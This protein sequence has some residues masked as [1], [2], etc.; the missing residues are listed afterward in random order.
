MATPSLNFW[1]WEET[2]V[3]DLS[4]LAPKKQVDLSNLKIKDTPKLPETP[5]TPQGAWLWPVAPAPW[6]RDFLASLQQTW[7]DFEAQATDIWEP[8]EAEPPTFNIETQ[9][10]PTWDE[11]DEVA[12]ELAP[13]EP[14]KLDKSIIKDF[15]QQWLAKWLN[16]EQLRVAFEKGKSQWRFDL[17]TEEVA[18]TPEWVTAQ[19]VTPPEDAWIL[20]KAKDIAEIPWR[21]AW[22]WLAQVPKILSNIGW[23]FIWKPID[24]LL[25]KVWVDESSLEEAFKKDWIRNKE[26]FQEKLWIDSES[27][28]TTLWEFG[29]EVG[30]LLTPW[31]QT[32]LI[33]KFPQAVDKIKKIWTVL[34]KVAE[35]APWTFN[36]LKSALTWAKEFGKFWIVSE[37]ELSKEWVVAWAVLSPV[38]WAWIK[39]F[40]KWTKVF[41]DKLQLSWLLNPAKLAQVSEQ[42][43]AEGI[44]KL[45]VAEHLLKNN[46]KGTKEKVVSQLNAL[47]KKSKDE[48][49]TSLANVKERFKNVE[50]VE[51]ALD[52]V[53]SKFSEAPWLKNEINRMSELLAKSQKWEWLALS[54]INEVKRTI[55]TF[56][57]PFTTTGTE[58][59]AQQWIANLRR[60][61]KW[62]IE[63]KSKEAWIKSIQQLNKNT[64]INTTLAQAITRKEA[65]DQAR[66][67]LTAFAPTWAWA[68]LWWVTWGFQWWDPFTILKNVLIWTAVWW[69]VWKTSVKTNAAQFFNK[70]SWPEKFEVLWFLES[71]WAKSIW[72]WLMSKII[73]TFKSNE[74]K[75]T[76]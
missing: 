27:F 16:K 39:L 71:K 67:I 56:V 47:A 11:F 30:S 41:A 62:F 31:W 29:A 70:L 35:K 61:I 4:N 34:E 44:E 74:D 65:S 45:T 21:I 51:E 50:P 37:W 75:S 12:E 5:E 36:V 14:Q 15:F 20:G 64:Q 2:N 52:F 57:S 66:E 46:I 23:F 9:K 28:T 58:K 63:V 54:E 7:K 43:K 72:T 59:A 13:Q 25:K 6:W 1:P 18:E 60:D 22:A 40:S 76:S 69:I 26:N 73:N 24:A 32:N 55:D 48:V 10:T 17:K 68:V 53:R 33:A 19:A 3:S 42:L 8:I 38:L 49:D